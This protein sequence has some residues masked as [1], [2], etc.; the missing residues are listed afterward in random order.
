MQRD[1]LLDYR[2]D[3]YRTPVGLGL[4]KIFAWCGDAMVEGV[5]IAAGLDGAWLVICEPYLGNHPLRHSNL[6]SAMA[7]GFSHL[8]SVH[9]AM[10]LQCCEANRTPGFDPDFDDHNSVVLWR[11]NPDEQ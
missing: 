10:C 2:V 11:D 6:K 8:R 3:R 4:V 1:G 7:A 9:N 5:D